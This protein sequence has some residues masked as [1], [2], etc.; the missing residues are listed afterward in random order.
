MTVPYLHSLPS[1]NGPERPQS[2]QRPQRS[3]SRQVGGIF[4]GHADDWDGDD[5]EI[6]GRPDGWEVIL[7][8]QGEPL[9]DHFEG[10]EDGE[11]HVGPAQDAHQTR[12]LFQVNVLEAEGDG[13]A[14]NQDQD[15]PFEGWMFDHLQEGFAA[16]PPLPTDGLQAAPV[17]PAAALLVDR[18]REAVGWFLGYFFLAGQNDGRRVGSRQFGR[19]DRR[20]HVQD[21]RDQNAPVRDVVGFGVRLLRDGLPLL[22]RLRCHGIFPGQFRL[23]RPHGPLLRRSVNGPQ[24]DAGAVVETAGQTNSTSPAG[25]YGRRNVNGRS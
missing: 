18:L 24:V 8:T 2:S 17:F 21:G 6:Q 25:G 10:E 11:R 3:K 22:G 5:D 1:R 13:R 15:G 16:G 12:I 14:E 4:D 23:W 20:Q 7:E 9:D 19:F